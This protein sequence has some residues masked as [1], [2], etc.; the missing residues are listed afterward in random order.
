M[1]FTIISISLFFFS[2]P[3]GR[4]I[5][6]EKGRRHF[7]QCHL[8]LYLFHFSFFPLPWGEELKGKKGEDTSSNAI[9]Y[10]IYFTF[11]FFLS[12]GERVG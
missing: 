8:L 7:L 6:E 10:Y 4:G 2:S 9:Y 5:K 3:L 1:P 12:L 11:L